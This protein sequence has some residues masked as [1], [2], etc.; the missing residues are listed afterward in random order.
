MSPLPCSGFWHL[1]RLPSRVTRTVLD[2]TYRARQLRGVL[3]RSEVDTWIH[4][5]ATYREVEQQHTLGIQGPSEKVFGVGLAVWRAQIPAKEVLG[6]A[7]HAHP[8]YHADLGSMG[9]ST[10]PGRSP[11]SIAGNPIFMHCLP[12]PLISLSNSH[13]FKLF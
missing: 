4:G 5:Q 9:L 11:G 12:V 6:G 2:D 8:I 7:I 1:Q 10:A 3:Q 13:E